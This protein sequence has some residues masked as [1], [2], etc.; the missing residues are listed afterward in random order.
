MKTI[1]T[2]SVVTL[3]ATFLESSE[4]GCPN[5]VS[6][7]EWG[8]RSTTVANLKKNPP[9]YVV[10]HHSA[11]PQSCT[12]KAAC[13]AM[14]KSFQNSHIDNNHWEDI[15]YNFV[16]GEDGNVYE[17][18]GWGKLGSHAPGYNSKSI[19]ICIIGTFTS[20]KPNDAALQ[21]VKDL[22]SCGVS[23]NKISSDYNLIGHRQ[24]KRT[25][26]PGDKLYDEI[27][28]WPRWTSTP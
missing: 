2:I 5:I 16:V 18:R 22:I 20:R 12:S 28:S 10:I 7:S 13:S 15:G 25:E 1:F 23:Q 21:A 27:K 14:V 8:A 6:R 24:A 19:G 4:A 9:T 11:N 26:C 17:G 3:L